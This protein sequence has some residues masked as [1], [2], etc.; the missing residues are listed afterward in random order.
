MMNNNTLMQRVVIVIAVLFWFSP[1][2]LIA[3]NLIVNGDFESYN[4]Y[5]EITAPS[6]T[7]YQRVNANYVVEAGHYVINSTTSG[8]GGGQG[9]PMPDD[10]HGKFMIV[11]GYGGNTNLTKVVWKQTVPVTTQTN[12]TFTCRVVNLN[13]I[14]YGQINPAKLQL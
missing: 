12:Y 10:P 11:N 8:H 6:Y 2:W 4:T 9:W 13:R 3:Q 5:G 7:D 14:Y 1:S